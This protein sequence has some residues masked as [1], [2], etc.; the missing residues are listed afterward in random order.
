M[1]IVVLSVAIIA[2]IVGFALL[3]TP[4]QRSPG[5]YAGS[6]EVEPA[7]YR[8]PSFHGLHATQEF[9]LVLNVTVRNTGSL[10][11][12]LNRTS[13]AVLNPNGSISKLPSDLFNSSM[14]IPVGQAVRGTIVFDV[15]GSNWLAKLFARLPNGNGLV[16]ALTTTLPL[17]VT[18]TCRTGDF[19]NWSLWVSFVPLALS[20]WDMNLTILSS[21]G[22][23]ILPKKSLPDLAYS[24]DHVA[25]IYSIY[26]DRQWLM[27]GDRLLI[28]TST[29]PAGSQ[30]ELSNG[31]R[32]WF[33]LILQP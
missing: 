32:V 1:I 17:K 12:N 5:T 6:L 33:S 2:S 25:F 28:N 23:M 3:G 15:Y 8:S 14:F 4:L 16:A 29:Y 22:S 27:P 9:F 19:T 18:C 31:A 20:A 24:R 30:V 26:S 11:L 7:D 13:W 21:S 10:D